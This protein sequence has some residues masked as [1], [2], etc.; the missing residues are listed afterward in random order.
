M[1]G[2]R[3]SCMFRGLRAVLARIFL[4]VNNVILVS[5]AGLVLW[6]TLSPLVYELFNLGKISVGPPVFAVMFLVPMIPLMVNSSAIGMHSA[7]RRGRLAASAKPLW[8]CSVPLHS[9][10]C[11]CKKW[12]SAR[13]T[14]RPHRPVFGFWIIFSALIDP[15]QRLRRGQKLTAGLLGMVTAHIGVGVFRDRRERGRKLQ[16]REGR[17]LEAGDELF[18]AGYDFRYVGSAEVR[19][20]NYDAVRAEI[21]VTR[22]GKL[23][24]VLRPEK[25]HFGCSRPTTARRRFGQLVARF[26]RGDGQPVGCRC[27]E[28][29]HQYKPWSGTSGWVR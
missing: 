11:C 26:V 13:S 22:G 12:D 7:W 9:W 17:R 2:A 28:H 24:T 1:R 29:A 19:G 23:V 6:G 14:G 21:D 25:R 10:R 27:L 16:D 18:D 3:R 20:P 15:V 5:V 8:W 4:L